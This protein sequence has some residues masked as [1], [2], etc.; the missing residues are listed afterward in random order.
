VLDDKLIA[1]KNNLAILKLT[2]R[3]FFKIPLEENVSNIRYSTETNKMYVCM[4]VCTYVCMYV[5]MYVCVY[6]FLCM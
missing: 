3:E 1:I 2:S 5:C 6:V 4:Y